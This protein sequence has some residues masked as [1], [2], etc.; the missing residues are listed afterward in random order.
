MGHGARARFAD[1]ALAVAQHERVT[2]ADQL[3]RSLDRDRRAQGDF[4]GAVAA[5]RL[6]EAGREQARDLAAVAGQ[7]RAVEA[8]RDGKGVV[9]RFS[10][11]RNLPCRHG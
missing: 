9:H 8:A 3:E 4:H 6:A 2:V 7:A 10:A 1:E 11:A 5:E